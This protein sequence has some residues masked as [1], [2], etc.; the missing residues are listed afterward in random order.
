M[1]LVMIQVGSVLL[2]LAGAC[3]LFLSV[4]RT[5]QMLALLRADTHLRDWR[6]LFVLMNFFLAGYG[7]AALLVLADQHE[8][9]VLL[10]GVVFFFGAIFVYIVVRLQ[11]LTFHEVMGR[12]DAQNI[13]E[14]SLRRV[15]QELERRAQE[16]AALNII[17]QTAMQTNDLHAT[18]EIACQ[19]VTELFRNHS[20]S[21]GLFDRSSMTQL[22]I[23]A[24]YAEQ[25]R[26]RLRPGTIFQINPVCPICQEIQACRAVVATTAEAEPLLASLC[27]LS[28]F[29]GQERLL[30]TPLCF[31]KRLLGVLIIIGN[32]EQQ[33]FSS[34]DM[35]IAETVAESLVWAILQSEWHHADITPT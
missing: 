21:V 26:M 3:I 2:I 6:W 35:N 16:F 29:S 10:T 31:E 4:R 33:E 27:R 20:T 12:L 7:G 5:K 9:L 22:Q 1:N 13:A 19:A 25:S 17:A 34:T 15:N 30:L 8:F 32:A 18:L 24:S 28:G 11:H 23:T 14:A